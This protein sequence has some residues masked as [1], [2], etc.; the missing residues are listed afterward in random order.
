MQA[1]MA[2]EFGRARCDVTVWGG[3]GQTSRG[4]LNLK[5]NGAERRQAARRLADARGAADAASALSG[6]RELTHSV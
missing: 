3:M 2:T 5:K 6:A 4:G 1:D